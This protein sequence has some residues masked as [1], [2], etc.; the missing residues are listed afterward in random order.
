M[1][2]MQQ[3]RCWRVTLLRFWLHPSPQWEVYVDK[4]IFEIGFKTLKHFILISILGWNLFIIFN[5]FINIAFQEQIFEYL[6]MVV[7]FVRGK[8]MYDF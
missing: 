2:I 8:I 5:W 1:S 3:L 6:K 4:A 7:T